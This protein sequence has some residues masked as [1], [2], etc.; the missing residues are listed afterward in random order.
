AAPPGRGALW[1]PMNY[2]VYLGLKRYGYHAEAAELARKGFA[3]ARALG[4]QASLP[5]G[6]G[7]SALAGKP[8]AGMPALPGLTGGYDDQFLRAGWRPVVGRTSGGGG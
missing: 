2:L 7:Q 6:S 1:A 5:A 3:I 4:A 8:Q